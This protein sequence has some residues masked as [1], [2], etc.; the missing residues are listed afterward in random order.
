MPPVL[1]HDQA[2]GE[3]EALENARVDGI[4][5][6][7]SSQRPDRGRTAFCGVPACSPHGSVGHKLVRAFLK[8]QSW[9][10]G[11]RGQAPIQV[12]TSLSSGY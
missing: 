9:A 12:E 6:A 2:F 4:F 5:L 8:P 11:H 1:T 10:P 7:N 3:L